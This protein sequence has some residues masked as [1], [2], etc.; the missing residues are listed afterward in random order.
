MNTTCF[1]CGNRAD[2]Q[3]HVVPKC[4][5]GIQTVPLCVKCHNLARSEGSPVSLSALAMVSALP[6]RPN[7][8][9]LE[10][11]L[12][13][14]KLHRFDQSTRVPSKDIVFRYRKIVEFALSELFECM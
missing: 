5:G 2:H 10:T 9:T 6:R 4:L 3:H 7:K 1:E 13:A 11:A 8:L 12:I 14:R